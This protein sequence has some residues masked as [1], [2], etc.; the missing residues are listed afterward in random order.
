MPW[1]IGGAALASG[2]LGADAAS[3]AAN[4]QQQSSQAA[5]AEQAR[6]YDQTRADNAPF[7][8]TGVAANGRLKQLLGLDT[9]YSGAD[10]GSLLNRF[11]TNDLNNDPVYQNGLQFGL[12]Q[13]TGA[14]NAR[15][16]AGGNYDSGATLK[17]LSR[18]GNDY[19]TTKANDAYN[20]F[21]TDQSNIYNRLAGVSGTGQTAVNNVTAAGT[22]AANNISG[23]LTGEGNSTAAGIVGGAN[24]WGGALQN[25]LTNY[26]G[27]NFLNS[28]MAKNNALG[29]NTNSYG[30]WGGLDPSTYGEN[31]G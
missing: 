26:Q 18:Y 24:A 8:N 19:G 30:T 6:Q 16:L 13:G 12:D 21:N 10:S 27:N 9:G 17:A 22:N 7:L 14:I 4:A 1:I 5:L 11:S 20:R 23:L 29:G 2:L 25:G 3:S 28:V 31:Y 15:A